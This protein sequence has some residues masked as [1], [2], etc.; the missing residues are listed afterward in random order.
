MTAAT[1]FVIVGGGSAGAVLANRLS[2]DP[3]IQVHLVEAGGRGRSPMIASPAGMVLLMKTGAVDWKFSTVPQQHLD[4]RTLF[5]AQGRTLGGTSSINGMIYSRGPASDYDDWSAM[6]GCSGWS[7]A[8]VLPFFKRS[9]TFAQGDPRFHG[10]HG[11][12]RVSRSPKLNPLSIAYLEAGIEAGYPFTADFNVSQEGFGVHDTTTF[13]GIRQDTGRVFLRPVLRRPNLRVSTKCHATKII[14]EAGRAVGVEY[15]RNGQSHVVRARQ[16]V[17]LSAGVFNTP[18]LLQLSG[19][20][21]PDTLRA[22]GV[23]VLHELPGVGRNLQDHLAVGYKVRSSQPVSLYSHMRPMGALK[24]AG[25]Y[26]GSRSGP[27]TTSGIETGSFL[28]VMPESPGPDVQYHF[29]PML[30]G[31]QGHELAREHGYQAYGNVARPHSRG[32]VSIASS[33][34]F[35]PPMIDLNYLGDRRDRDILRESLRVS[36]DIFAQPAFDLYRGEEVGPG[37]GNW[38]ERDLDAYIRQNA[39]PV[40]HSVGTCSM[41]EGPDGV[42]DEVLRVRGIE[43]LR[44]ADC[45]V[46]PRLMAS[47]TN[48]PAIM[49]GERCADFL[50]QST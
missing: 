12:L 37:R 6:P 45:S 20:G 16:E 36:R 34:P 8:D 32:T 26:V 4:G 15:H 47:N 33:S 23:E 42:V 27:L 18:K 39:D 41:G 25:S 11:E 14:I 21:A 50:L 1:D 3:T 29:V 24:A 5:Y 48:A 38:S 30:Y 10:H 44:I 7:Y 9:E 19:V 40:Y 2:A 49:I 35:D 46:I 17:I 22:A 28:K 13:N 43:A 31:K